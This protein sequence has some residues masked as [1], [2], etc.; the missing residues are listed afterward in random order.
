M[1]GA[2][3]ARSGTLAKGLE[4]LDFIGSNGKPVTL[5]Q[6]MA[7]LEMTKP[8]A[9]R[10]LATLVD[11]GFVRFDSNR[12]TYRL[13]MRLFELSREVWRDFDLRGAALA[14]MQALHEKTGETVSLAILSPDGGVYIDELQSRHHLREQTR[15]GRRVAKWQSAMGKALTSGLSFAERNRL[16]N[17]E[18]SEILK[19]GRYSG[20]PELNR[21]LDLVNARGYAI[22]IDEDVPG[23]SGVAAP[24]VDHRGITVAAISLSGASERLDRDTL[25]QLGANVIEATRTA[26]INAGGSPRS[27]SSAPLPTELVLQDAKVRADVGNLIGEGPV[28][29]TAGKHLFWVDICRPCIYRH[30]IASGVTDLFPQKEMITAVAD[31]GDGLL[32]AGQ[33]GIRVIDLQSGIVLRDLGH[34][35]AT[36]PTNRFNDG[37]LDRRGRFFVGTLAFNL[38]PGSGSFYRV[39]P[40]GTSSRLETGLTLPNGLGW[41]PD[42]TKMYLIDSYDQVLYEYDFNEDSGNISNRKVLIE[43]PKDEPG[44]PDGLDV[45]PDGTLWVA[46]WDGWAVRS[47]APDGRSIDTLGVPFPRPTSVAYLPGAKPR[48]FVTSARIRVS[49]ALLSQYPNAGHLIELSLA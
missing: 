18:L 32:V 41:S 10:M 34:P 38:A 25:H 43:F 30:D 36:I 5:R 48:L 11:Y 21:H 4:I 24:I 7:G 39:E 35:E 15:V 13:G 3:K 19:A 31:A 26:S 27:V 40:D 29:D 8:T 42:G 20:L 49:G 12:S 46:M 14:E 16:Q 23:I 45:G 6:V 1:K 33:S 28:F 37:K 9:H 47:F 44:N 17:L 2:A 22:E